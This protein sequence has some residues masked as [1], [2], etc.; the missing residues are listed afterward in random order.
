MKKTSKLMV[1]LAGA[2][3]ALAFSTSS[4]VSAATRE[5]GVDWSKYQGNYGKYGTAKD[6]FVIA[7]VGGTYNGYYVDQAT[8]NTQ[9]SS[10]IAAGKY[11]H[12][13]IWYQVGGN[14][15]VAKAAMDRFLPRVQTPK[16]SIVALDY[17]AG[18]SGDKQANTN[19]II[20]GLNR[21]KAAGYTPVLYSGKYYLNDNTYYSQINK[22]FPN[23]LWIAGYP[24]N[25]VQTEAPFKYFPSYD[26]IAIWQFTSSYGSA[27]LDGNV[28][29]LGIT[30][31]GYDG[32]HK[33][34]TG[35][36]VV[37]PN[38]STPATSAGQAANHTAKAD[39]KAGTTVKVNLSASRWATGQS[40]PSYIKGK[41]YTVRQVSGD[42]VL[43]DGVMSWAKK[44]DVEILATS[45]AQPVS[46]FDYAQRGLYRPS[47]TVNVR[48]GAGTQYKV[49]GHL[50]Y[51]DHITYNHVYVKNGMVWARY[52][53]YTGVRYVALGVMGGKA[54]GTRSVY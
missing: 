19:T 21:V 13:Y 54:Y 29:L 31:K 51:G 17:E 10:A 11:A 8:Y 4:I 40:I 32:S 46:S 52:Q 39:I 43:L 27:G 49:T 16:G 42:R 48:T 12:T 2:V 24:L 26:G 50:G 18:A 41:T 37:T 45:T 28:D 36:V 33:T 35:K 22:A 30:H 9:V 3:M 14:T 15:T 47:V 6:K 34:D 5:Y 38:T 44:T 53:S 25:G 7:Q 20:Y 1:V 23:S